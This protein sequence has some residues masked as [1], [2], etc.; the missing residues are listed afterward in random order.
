M[1]WCLVL[2]LLL[3]GVACSDDSVAE[4]GSAEV[5]LQLNWL[6]EPQFGGFYEAERI[7]AFTDRRLTVDISPGGPDLS[8]VQIVGGGGATFGICAADE[9]LIARSKGN[10]V[11]ALFAA[12][13]T[14][15]QGLMLKADDP[16]DSIGALFERGGL[17]AW[18]SGL[19]YATYLK[20]NLGD[21]FE[22][23]YP[24]PFGDLTEFR[25][26]DEYAMQVFVTS[27][28]ITAR[29]EGLDV[30]TFLIADGGYNPYATV[31]I[32]KREFLEANPDVC[33]RMIQAVRA[34]WESYLA[35]PTSANAIMRELNPTMTAD[36]FIA[37][38]EAQKPLIEAEPLGAMSAERWQSLA[39]QLVSVGALQDTSVVDGAFVE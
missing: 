4:D 31:L 30:K 3:V 37:S 26:A 22:A 27:E 17:I 39:E 25:M 21:N 12:Y 34:G 24:S 2:T 20:Q 5:T 18:Q 11:V 35:D 23:E 15:P 16:A 38:A 28:P 6:P 32:C 8:P 36:A 10:D 14:N 9:L 19:P 7:G 1:R 29:R 33:A 13:Q